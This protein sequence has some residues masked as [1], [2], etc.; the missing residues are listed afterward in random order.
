MYQKH[1]ISTFDIPLL[2][3]VIALT[4]FGIVAIGSATRVNINGFTGEAVS[5]IIWLVTGLVL[6]FAAAFFDYHTICGL[7]IPIYV[8]NLVLLGAVLLFGSGDGVSRWLFGIQPSE[9][10]KIFI[11]ISLSKFIDKSEEKIN[12]ID[13]LFAAVALAGVPFLLV[14]L[15]PSLSASMVIAAITAVL[16]FC[17]G[18]SRKYILV[19]L[20]VVIPIGIILFI[21]IMSDD[22]IILGKFLTDYQISRL[23]SFLSSDVSGTDPT[24]YQTKNSIWAIGSGG[25]KGKG[26]YGGTINQLNYLPE[27][28][29]DFIF[30]VI[31]EEFGFIGCLGV[32]IA[33]FV[34]ISR[35]VMIGAGAADSLGRLLCCGV[36]GMIAFQTF[37]NIG[38]AT[39]IL[40]NTGMPLPFVSYGGSSLW[41]NMTGIGLVLNVGL[42]RQRER[43]F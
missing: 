42:R 20:A 23:V 32:I 6:L 41:V 22:H 36:G 4:S 14:F 40:P 10:A 29:N 18:L 37:V 16:I 19:F 43:Y 13:I 2:V 24:L 12:N 28:H 21:D 8:L 26:L 25:L 7:W 31:G 5:Q 39:G 3:L 38:V 17:G 15:Q 30:S 9:F 27:S 33:L 11:I 35:C 1:R 34:I